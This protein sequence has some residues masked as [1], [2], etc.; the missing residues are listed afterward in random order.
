MKAPLYCIVGKRPVKS[1][2]D[3]K[4]GDLYIYAYRWE[5][6]VFESAMEY[7][8]RLYMGNQDDVTFVS[9][10]EFE[11]YTEKLEKERLKKSNK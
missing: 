9:K 7:F 5:D 2:K 6:G 3:L 4:T 11:E 10:Q 1:E 8:D